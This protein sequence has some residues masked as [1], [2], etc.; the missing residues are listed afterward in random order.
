MR[1]SNSRNASQNEHRTCNKVA[2]VAQDKGTLQPVYLCIMFEFEE[3][4]VN[5]PVDADC[6]ADQFQGRV[7]RVLPDEVVT[8]EGCQVFAADS[9]SELWVVNT[10]YQPMP[11]TA[12]CGGWDSPL[13]HDLHTAPAP[14]CSSYAPPIDS[15]THS[16]YAHPRSARDRTKARPSS[17]SER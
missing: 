6:A 15:Q 11:P 17:L 10:V 16:K 9:T 3:E 4:F 2:V 7:C 5:D 14:S 12:I 8:V 13:A 1:G